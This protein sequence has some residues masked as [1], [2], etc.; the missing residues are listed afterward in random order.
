MGI[1][2]RAV[3]GMPSGARATISARVITSEANVPKA[4]PTT[5][6]PSATLDTPGPTSSTRPQNSPPSS[7][8][9]ITARARNM[10]QKFKP[11]ASIATRTSFASSDRSGRRT[12]SMFSSAPPSSGASSQPDSVGRISRPGSVPARTSRAAWRR[13]SR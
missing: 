2:A 13:P 9:S 10:S 1:V 3:T 11:V 4:R 6:S 8:S 5:R 12:T 7:P